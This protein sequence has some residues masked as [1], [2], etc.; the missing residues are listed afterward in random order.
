MT[1]TNDFVSFLFCPVRFVGPGFL[2]IDIVTGKGESIWDTYL[3]KHP[4][5][6][7]DHSN[8]DVAADSY[9]KYKQDVTMVQTLGVKYYRISLSWTR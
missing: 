7:L 8:G 9:H 4:H 3:H 6:T 1:K 5:Y 2:I